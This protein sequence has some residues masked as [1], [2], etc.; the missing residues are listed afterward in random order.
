M[1]RV[2]PALPFVAGRAEAWAV[3]LAARRPR[4]CGWCEGVADG[5][6]ASSRGSVVGLLP[7]LRFTQGQLK[8]VLD[9]QQSRAK[10]G[11]ALLL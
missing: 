8:Q 11:R 5:A 7:F 10:N 2:G 1:A 6:E 9:K 4:A 3:L